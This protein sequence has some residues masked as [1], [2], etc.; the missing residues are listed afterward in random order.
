MSHMSFI[1]DVIFKRSLIHFLRPD[2][3]LDGVEAVA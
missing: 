1:D 2:P 3:L